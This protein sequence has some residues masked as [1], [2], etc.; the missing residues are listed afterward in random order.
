[1]FADDFPADLMAPGI[2]TCRTCGAAE[3]KEFPNY[4]AM[5]RVTSD[6]W[7]F[8]PGGRLAVC[9]DCGAVQKPTDA[10]WYAE[11]DAIYR[12]YKPYHQA[13]GVEQAAIDPTMGTARRRSEVVLDRTLQVYAAR[14]TGAI[15]DVGCG[16]GALLRAF[17]AMRPDW[18]LCGHELSDLHAAALATIPGF[19][20][21]HRGQ[22]AE[23][24]SGFDL[25][26]MM[27]ALEH[28]PDPVA[29]LLD[30]RAKLD[31]DGALLIEVPNAE[32]NP[33]D[34]LIADHVCH[35]TREDL[36]RVIGRAGMAVAALADDWVGKE[37]S[38]V[39][40]PR[41]PAVA[42]PPPPNGRA[43]FDRV[44][45]QLEWLESL[46]RDAREGARGRSFG[47][48]GTSIAAMWLFGVLGD[49]I[50]FFVDEDP[51]RGSTTLCGR[52]VYA[53]VDIPA[54]ATVFVAL[55]PATARTVAARLAGPH[56]TFRLPADIGARRAG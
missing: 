15:L 4:G 28:F 44:R 53:P 54:G 40:L 48:F 34:L 52:P 55:I 51:N 36:R 10:N 20:T 24:P 42:S 32:A 30:L 8:P 47:L 22:L 2:F 14:S 26:T 56:V 41:A 35:F 25:I 49:Q 1:M 18:R 23:L 31:P 50:E 17:A 19:T 38:A 12:N 11:V 37:L 6:C 46:I 3:L 21:L 29:S 9:G 33:F 43:A 7:A 39:A 45:S 5:P 27:H 16:N 13:G